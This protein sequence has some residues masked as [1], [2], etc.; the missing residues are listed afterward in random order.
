[1]HKTVIRAFICSF[2]VSLLTILTANRVFCYASQSTPKPLEISKKNIVLFLKNTKPD[3]LPVKKI[4]LA[5]LPDIEPKAESSSNSEHEIILANNLEDW[6]FPIEITPSENSSDAVQELVLADVLYAPNKPL[7]YPEITEDVVYT[8]E[9]NISDPKTFTDQDLQNREVVY[10]SLDAGDSKNSSIVPTVSEKIEKNESLVIA[11][12]EKS[13]PI[14]LQKSKKTRPEKKDVKIGNPQ[15]LNH[16]A[17]NNTTIP[18]QSM[19][20][21][22][23]ENSENSSENR[24]WI[25]MQDD[26]WI[27]AQ[28]TGG[29]N[30]LAGKAASEISATLNPKQ[31]RSQV[32]VASETVKNLIIPIPSNIMDDDDLT[33]KLAYPPT[34]EDAAKEKII[35][36]QIKEQEKLAEQLENE[37]RKSL[38]TPIDEEISLDADK[39]SSENEVAAQAEKDAANTKAVAT[40]MGFAGTLASIFSQSPDD[41]NKAKEKAFAKAKAKGSIQRTQK[42]SKPVSIMPA[43][44]RLSFQPNRAEISGQ[45]L[46][47]IQ[48]FATKAAETPNVSLEIRIDGTS[49]TELQQRRLNLIHNI[50]TNKGVDYSKINTVFTSREP[51]SFVLRTINSEG[52]TKE[53]TNQ[54]SL[55]YIQ[56]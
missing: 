40:N 39:S 15:D 13:A 44:I 23:T 55:Q 56:W 28:S 14:P 43:E 32:Q 3:K 45:S 38:L 9:K 36:A 7:D 41:I 54:R 34:S 46:R 48:A 50:L 22:L 20:K 47:W 24:N 33:P 26:P 19:E 21:S 31:K 17:M 42:K 6:E 18:I 12:N 30:Q 27:I 5:T 52:A 2:S 1:M 51:N 29:K 53:N 8:P 16:I 4:A 35:D 37:E 49:S 10:A 11:E 25:E